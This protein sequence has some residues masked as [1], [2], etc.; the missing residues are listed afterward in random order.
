MKGTGRWKSAIF[1]PTSLNYWIHAHHKLSR[2]EGMTR[3]NAEIPEKHRFMTNIVRLGGLRWQEIMKLPTV[4]SENHSEGCGGG[5]LHVNRIITD[6]CGIDAF[7]PWRRTISP[8]NVNVDNWVVSIRFKHHVTRTEAITPL[9]Q[10]REFPCLQQLLSLLC[11]TNF[12]NVS[13][14]EKL[15]FT[16]SR[17]ETYR[18]HKKLCCM[19]SFDKFE[20]SVIVLWLGEMCSG[21]YCEKN[22]LMIQFRAEINH[23]VE[24]LRFFR[25]FRK[26]RCF[27]KRFWKAISLVLRGIRR[28]LHKHF[29]WLSEN[30]KLEF[31]V[32][33]TVR[34]KLVSIFQFC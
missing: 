22:D 28:K 10:H 14:S 23:E 19:H 9:Q 5:K 13:V 12:L 1:S 7:P 27:E 20:H 26:Y 33:I 34:A 2:K 31:M 11:S 18:Q 4:N 30:Q 32:Q 29:C 16:L 24:F 17:A 21:F 15:F 3:K 6:I 25:S 8:R